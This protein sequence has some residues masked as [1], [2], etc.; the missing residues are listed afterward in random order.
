M[1]FY[2]IK[3]KNLILYTCFVAAPCF[4]GCSLFF[5]L[6]P[7]FCCSPFLFCFVWR[8]PV[9]CCS[10]FLFCLATPCFVAAPCFFCSGHPASLSSAAA[11]YNWY[12]FK[13]LNSYIPCFRL[14][15]GGF[16]PPT[17]GLWAQHASSAPPRFFFCVW[18]TNF[19]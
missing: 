8:L 18:L 9:F 14:T 17:S 16:D 13:T 4:F 6:L 1:N 10:L 12:Y 5:W 2:K 15:G 3:Q 11:S 7:V 19:F